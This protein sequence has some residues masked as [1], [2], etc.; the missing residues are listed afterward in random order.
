MKNSERAEQ[1]DNLI[2]NHVF[3][4]SHRE[5]IGLEGL[6]IIP[7]FACEICAARMWASVAPVIVIFMEAAL[8]NS[9]SLFNRIRDDI[10]SAP[11]ASMTR[12]ISP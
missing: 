7:M 5:G 2:E 11:C 1:Y 4:S 12:G 6:M 9:T 10:I 8:D 3:I